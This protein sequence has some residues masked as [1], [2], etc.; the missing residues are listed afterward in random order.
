MPRY[1]PVRSPFY[2]E[3][4]R[5]PYTRGPNYTR[6]MFREQGRQGYFTAQPMNRM[7]GLR[8]LGSAIGPDKA[9]EC[10]NTCDSSCAPQDTACFKTCIDKCTFQGDNTAPPPDPVAATKCSDACNDLLGTPKYT[11]C[12]IACGV[13]V[14]PEAPAAAQAGFFSGFFQ[15]P[16]KMV[17]TL[18]VVGGVLW[19][20]SN[21][22]KSPA[23]VSAPVRRRYR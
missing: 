15:S 20:M 12:L 10:Y 5:W 18:A 1:L 14:N 17:A 3:Y 23:V 19:W 21:R 7:P 4:E 2:A 13:K 9:K 22:S 11:D 16:T 8:G 6:A